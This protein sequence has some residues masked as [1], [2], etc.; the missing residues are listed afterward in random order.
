MDAQTGEDE[1]DQ[2]TNWYVHKD[3]N[4]N[5][6]DYDKIN[7]DLDSKDKV[8]HIEM[9]DLWFSMRRWLVVE[10]EWQQM[11]KYWEGLEEKSSCTDW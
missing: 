1:N 3:V 6:S 7:K 2:L 8:M 9:S 4:Q 10:K 5:K 11:S